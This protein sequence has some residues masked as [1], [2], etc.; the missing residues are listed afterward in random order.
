MPSPDMQESGL[1][2]TALILRRLLKFSET[3][4]LS[5]PPSIEITMALLDGR[6]IPANIK[7][8]SDD[9]TQLLKLDFMNRLNDLPKD[10]DKKS[11][12][13]FEKHILGH[14]TDD[15]IASKALRT[16]TD[17]QLKNT[18]KIRASV[19]EGFCQLMLE[20]IQNS[21]VQ[22]KIKLCLFLNKHRQ[23]ED[24]QQEMTSA[25]TED[26]NYKIFQI[27][28]K[29]WQHIKYQPN[30]L[31]SIFQAIQEFDTDIKEHEFFEQ[32][33]DTALLKNEA[34]AGMLREIKEQCPKKDKV[35]LATI[36]RYIMAEESERK[37]LRAFNFV[38][39][40]V[41]SKDIY[42]LLSVFKGLVDGALHLDNQHHMN[43]FQR[44]KQL[45]SHVFDDW[46]PYIQQVG[47]NLF[48]A[49]LINIYHEHMYGL[50]R[51]HTIKTDEN[52][53]LWLYDWTRQELEHPTLEGFN[54]FIKK[55]H[56]EFLLDRT[57]YLSLI[58]I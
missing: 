1:A 12:R 52:L 28:Q 24:I 37:I 49:L 39:E 26:L 53:K 36:S 6:L 46:E 22:K 57:Q 3:S 50:L 56:P 20:H 16:S 35:F 9:E 27:K 55:N 30:Q 19:F 8:M 44:F 43:T 40:S 2:Y 48:N 34:I 21:D 14:Y 17:K 4:P 51:H 29:I 41:Q 33:A 13:W 47:S 54:K 42:E 18:D 23:G 38:F 7:P 11:M 45:R 32:V 15:I 10:I 31:E 5:N 58:H 25:F